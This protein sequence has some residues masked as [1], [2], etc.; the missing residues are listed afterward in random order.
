MIIIPRDIFHFLQK[1]RNCVTYFYSVGGRVTGGINPYSLIWTRTYGW[2]LKISQFVHNGGETPS[3]SKIVKRQV[4]NPASTSHP[5][6]ETGG[7]NISGGNKI[8]A[9]KDGVNN[10]HLSLMS[11]FVKDGIREKYKRGSL[12][13]IKEEMQKQNS[14]PTLWSSIL[15]KIYK[16]FGSESIEPDKMVNLIKSL[17]VD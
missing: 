10:P 2:T 7:N 13:E 11:I 8:S 15:Q 12:I 1:I 4:N 5:L 3:L 17:I 6:R 14:W 16:V 9:K